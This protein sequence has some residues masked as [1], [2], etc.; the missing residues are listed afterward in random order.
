[1]AKAR[2]MARKE[3]TAS[4]AEPKTRGMEETQFCG[5]RR[6]RPMQHGRK[7]KMALAQFT[8]R[9]RHMTSFVVASRAK[10]TTT[11]PR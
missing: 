3:F 9:M 2:A 1:M 7:S 8:T 11:I 5:P 6:R 10:A 4:T